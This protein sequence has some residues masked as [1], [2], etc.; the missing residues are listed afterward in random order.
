[1]TQINSYLTFSGN[2]REA[3]T[4]YKDC[5]GGEL[6]LQSIGDSPMVDQWP[7]SARNNILHASLVKSSLV[8]LA[9]DLSG[10]GPLI[11]GNSIS[12]SLNCSS[13]QEIETFFNKLAKGGQVVHPLHEFFAGT[14]GT[15]TDK[16]EKDWLLY[17]ERK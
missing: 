3:M 4:F 2:C 12:L 8:L 11:K 5:L 10:R 1:M 16:F 7:N 17:C 6:T 15:L 13:K 14:M 9:S